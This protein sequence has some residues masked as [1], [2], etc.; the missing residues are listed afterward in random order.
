MPGRDRQRPG[1]P[2][3]R[4]PG[5]SGRAGHDG[6][7]AR[8]LRRRA[9]HRRR[10]SSRSSAAPAW[11]T[12]STPSAV[13]PPPADAS[14]DQVHAWWAALTPTQQLAVVPAP[15]RQGRQP[16]RCRG[17]GAR[18]RE[19][20]PAARSCASS[21]ERQLA[22]ATS[23]EHP[24][25][26]YG[27]G[28][29]I[30]PAE[31]QELRDKL[32]GLDSVQEVLDLGGRQL[33][34]LDADSGSQLHA[35]VAVGD[36]DTAG[37]RL[38]VHPG[39]HHHREG[40]PERHRLRHGPASRSKRPAGAGPATAASTRWRPSSWLGYDAPQW[41]GV[42]FP[43]PERR[44][45]RPGEEGRRRPGAVLLRA[46]TPRGTS[47]RTSPPSATP[48]GPPRPASRS[49][50][51]APVSTTRSSSVHPGLGTSERDDLHVPEGHLFRVEARRDPVADLAAFGLDPT[52]LDGVDG[53]SAKES[54]IDGQQY[55]ESTGHSEYLDDGT[56]QPVQHRGHGGRPTRSA[57]PR[58]WSRS[59]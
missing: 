41:D 47:I 56:H 17:L 32:A 43:L 7:P 30:E 23:G 58:R 55:Q 59:R 54:D 21:C 26:P 12:C 2:G 4:R 9:R 36:V 11:C 44:L 18:H 57:G 16:R 46:S 25:E 28:F 49:S 27:S 22:D 13:T 51:T 42:A 1:G 39:L 8:P 48:T 50:T 6:G 40:Q 3:P 19:P 10:R 14:P 15:E 20:H 53:L 31:A 29:Y 33:L 37:P 52:W 5:Q 45:R 38:G 35:A 34:V 24:Y